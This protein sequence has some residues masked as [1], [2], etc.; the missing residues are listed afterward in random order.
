MVSLLIKQTYKVLILGK[1]KRPL[2]VV[3][4]LGRRRMRSQLS[5]AIV[6]SG[7]DVLCTKA[8]GNK[9]IRR[10]TVVKLEYANG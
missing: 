10:R 8:P 7:S 5:L 2:N 3:T 9:A 1:R 6:S 4:L